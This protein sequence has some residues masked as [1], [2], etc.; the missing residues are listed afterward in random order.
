VLFAPLR[1]RLQRAVD[2]LMYG[3][4]DEPYT[5]VSRLGRRL[6]APY[7]PSSP[8]APLYTIVETIAQALKLPGAAI[9]LK[10]S[11]AA[12]GDG[13]AARYGDT[14][15]ELVPLPLTYAGEVLGE[16]LLAPRAPGERFTAADLRLLADLARQAGVA[17][18][19]VRLSADL[20][21]SRQ[22]IVETREEARRRLGRDLHD[23]VGHRLAALL[24][25]SDAA[26][27]VLRQDPAAAEALLAEVRAQTRA[28]I[29]EVRALAHALHPPELELLGLAAAVQERAGSLDGLWV[30]VDVPP[31]LPR[32]STA[33]EAA[34]YYI[35]QEALTNVQKHAQAAHC[36]VTLRLLRGA[37]AAG[38]RAATGGAPRGLL[39]ITVA[40]DGRG[41]P[42]QAEGAWGLGLT[43]LA[44]R[45]AEIGGRCTIARGAAGGT[46]VHAQL[47]YYPGSGS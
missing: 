38:P 6:E 23:G 25:K 4:R 14:T 34:A 24:G 44:E 18:H 12:P 41:L 36:R 19:A 45:A 35:V 22:H 46:E 21:R 3:E 2:R 26:A 9:T 20:E 32:L 40:D 15:G 11:G 42:V 10:E 29:A 16:L 8:A 47:P 33:V 17:A 39:E 28:T 5:V 1:E 13:V 37:D 43:S 30:E 31:D 7:P 27:R